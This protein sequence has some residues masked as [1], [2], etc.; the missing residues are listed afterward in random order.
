MV[1]DSVPKLLQSPCVKEERVIPYRDNFIATRA[2]QCP[3]LKFSRGNRVSY[4]ASMA[5]TAESP[6]YVFLIFYASLQIL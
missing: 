3:V 2:C 1:H 6:P 4:E 5:I